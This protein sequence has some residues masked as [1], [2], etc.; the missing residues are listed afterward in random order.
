M[1]TDAASTSNS[2]ISARSSASTS[3][4]SSALDLTT[5]IGLNSRSIP[6]V[7]TF[8]SV[9]AA[10]TE[11]VP[12]SVLSSAS[13]PTS[14]ATDAVSLTLHGINGSWK[15]DWTRSDKSYDFF[16]ALGVPFLLRPLVAIADTMTPIYQLQLSD[17]E[18]TIRGGLTSSV[19]RFFFHS[20]SEWASPDGGKHPATL[21]VDKNSGVLVIYVTHTTR[22][23]DIKMTYRLAGADLIMEFELLNRTSKK[24][25]K[26]FKRTYKKD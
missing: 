3:S 6:D 12:S 2:A 19:D 21:S 8:S 10:V 9:G 14:V 20:S 23:V 4:N 16:M 22:L 17:D 25:E 15:L 11:A 26:A 7:S 24:I 18:F 1:P 5:A 13:I